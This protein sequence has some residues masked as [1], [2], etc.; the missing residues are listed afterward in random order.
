MTTKISDEIL[1][2]RYT[3]KWITPSEDSLSRQGVWI[4]VLP[5]KPTSPHPRSSAII[6][7][8]FGLEASCAML[9]WNVQKGDS[10][11]NNWEFVFM[12][13]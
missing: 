4:R 2:R 8:M 9:M 1:E 7:I 3:E 11:N 5:L 13:L 10:N 12:I 6:S